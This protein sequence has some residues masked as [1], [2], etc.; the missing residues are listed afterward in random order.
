MFLKALKRFNHHNPGEVFEASDADGK[1]W[2]AE[3]LAK[4]TAKEEEKAPDGPPEDK[5]AKKAPEKK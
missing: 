4:K 1:F 2:I 3:G 5:A